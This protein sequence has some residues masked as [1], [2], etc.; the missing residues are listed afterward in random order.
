MEYRCE[1]RREAFDDDLTTLSQ[2]PEFT[3]TAALA[4]GGRMQVLI[5][6]VNHVLTYGKVLGVREPWRTTAWAP[7]SLLLSHLQP[8]ALEGSS[9]NDCT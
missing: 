3:E 2:T 8:L 4:H 6:P 1:P 5:L 7:W 9:V